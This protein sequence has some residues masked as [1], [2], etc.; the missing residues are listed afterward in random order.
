MLLLR[1]FG[2]NTDTSNYAGHWWDLHGVITSPPGDLGGLP[3]LA[4]VDG[5]WLLVG[6]LRGLRIPGSS[7]K[8]IQWHENVNTGKKN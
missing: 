7:K 3:G 4:P 5:H 1:A 6:A 8:I 2:P